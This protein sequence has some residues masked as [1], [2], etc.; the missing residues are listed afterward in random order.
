[1]SFKTVTFPMDLILTKEN[2]YDEYFLAEPSSYGGYDE[3]VIK[4]VTASVNL[5]PYL[6]DAVLSSQLSKQQ[7]SIN[8]IVSLAGETP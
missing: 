7:L 5:P 1:M 3:D 4:T 2:G 6:A 8:D